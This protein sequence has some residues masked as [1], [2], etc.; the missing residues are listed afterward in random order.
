[1]EGRRCAT[2]MSWEKATVRKNVLYILDTD[3]LFN[4]SQEEIK[5]LLFVNLVLFA[6]F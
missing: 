6:T 4:E 3:T 2:E 5:L 1:M